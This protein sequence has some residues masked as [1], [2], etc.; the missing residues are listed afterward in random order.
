MAATWCAGRRRAAQRCGSTS[1]VAP[2]T[3]RGPAIV[4]VASLSAGSKRSARTRAAGSGNRHGG[5]LPRPRAAAARRSQLRG[6]RRHDRNR[7]ARVR[8][9]YWAN[10][11]SRKNPGWPR[12]TVAAQ[13]S[14]A[15]PAA[16]LASQKVN[17]GKR[18]DLRSATAAVAV[19]GKCA[20]ALRLS[21]L[22]RTRRSPACSSGL[23]CAFRCV[24]FCWCWGGACRAVSAGGHVGT[25]R[26]VAG[27]QRRLLGRGARW[28]DRDRGRHDLAGETKRWLDEWCPS[29]RL[30]PGAPPAGCGGAG[31]SNVRIR[32]WPAVV[33]G[34]QWRWGGVAGLVASRFR[35]PARA[36]GGRGHRGAFMLRAG[37]GRAV[38]VGGSTTIRPRW[39]VSARRFA[40]SIWRPAR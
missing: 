14:T 27:W 23:F 10:S 6:S 30:T 35:A 1:S 11:S 8:P 39:N 33:G 19:Q 17:E 18:I 21:R 20:R 9:A 4:T 34:R 5:R 13:I 24:I 22:A 38:V 32:G 36:G 12:R 25:A 40:R 29:R 28:A 37:G 16:R 26:L 15:S 2:A 7:P 3:T 31:V